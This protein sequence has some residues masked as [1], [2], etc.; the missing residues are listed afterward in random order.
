LTLL[1]GLSFLGA[2]FVNVPIAMALG[3]AA[4]L[5]MLIFPG[6]MPLIIL[7]QSLYSSVDKVLLTA[8]PFFILAGNLMKAGGVTRRLVTFANSLVGSMHGGL[9]MVAIMTCI[10]FAGM[11]GSGPAEAAALGILMIPAMA[12]SGYKKGFAASLLASAGSLG[13]II[14]PSIP[15]IIYSDLTDVSVG[16]LFLAG[17][18]PGL[19]IG[20]ILMVFNYVI[21]LRRGYKGSER[22]SLGEIWKGFRGAILPLFTPLII[23]GGIYGG[24]FTPTES[25]V[26]AVIYALILGGVIYREI[27]LKD[28]PEILISTACTSSVALLIL[29]MA[30]TFGLVS[31]LE[32]LPGRIGNFIISMAPN[33]FVFLVFVI[34]F[35]FVVGCFMSEVAAMIIMIP[36]FLPALTAFHIHPVH[37]G[38]LMMLNIAIG[39][40]TP[41]Y[42]VNIFVTCSIARISIEE[43]AREVWPFLLALIISLLLITYFPGISLFLPNLLMR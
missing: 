11:T 28:L 19:L 22:R 37:F 32:D 13:I 36:I 7:P 40:M 6:G 15:M 38:V 10:F 26:V 2:M 31:T 33:G 20:G 1:L 41:P 5:A 42:G 14:P 4:T 35:L 29:A 9:G 8:V 23:V 43:Y 21:S 25:A 30:S 12:E 39:M 16:A 27:H 24:I 3:F 18:L 34:I 17:L